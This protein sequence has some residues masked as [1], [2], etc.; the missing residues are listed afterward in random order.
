MSEVTM[1]FTA[2]EAQA[3]AAIQKL[4]GA[5]AKLN[6][7]ID[8]T[9]KNGQKASAELKRFADRVKEI[10]TTPIERYTAH[11]NKLQQAMS[12]GL[13]TQRD[14]DRELNRYKTSLQ[15]SSGAI[16][17]A[18]GSLAMMAAGYMSVSTAL[19]MYNQMLSANRQLALDAAEANKS[20]ATAQQEAMK[21]MPDLSSSE[22]TRLMSVV[23]P[24]MQ[25]KTGFP[26]AAAMTSALG[27]VYSAPGTEA[28][29]L[30]AVEAAALLNINTPANLGNQ[31]ASALDIA[32]QTGS[33]NMKENISFLLEAGA[34][35]RVSSPDAI[36][37]NLPRV[38]GSAVQASPKQDPK[39]AAMEAGALYGTMAGTMTDVQGDISRHAAQA[40]IMRLAEVFRE[41]KD[42]PGST[43]GRLQAIQ[44]SPK[45]K[46][47]LFS[48]S[49]GDLASQDAFRS[50]TTA[51]SQ[52]SKEFE[53]SISQLPFSED[54][55][56]QQVRDTQ[57]A[58]PQLRFA[59]A[60]AASKGA[61]QQLQLTPEMTMRAFIE[62]EG[63]ETLQA[64]HRGTAN[65]LQNFMSR[66][67]QSME[68][69]INPLLGGSAEETFVNRLK[70]QESG[71][72][73]YDR[74]P[75]RDKKLQVLKETRERFEQLK[76]STQFD[77]AAAKMEKAAD[78]LAKVANMF[79]TSPLGSM[80]G[81]VVDYT[82]RARAEF[83][84][85]Q[86]Q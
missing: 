68:K 52:Q 69:N 14:V 50:L 40:L 58:T 84:H 74:T 29:R 46:K 33:Q 85:A 32:R 7:S 80:A 34:V 2:D 18:V 51:G 27:E 42:D 53:A 65:G 49:F 55:Y 70:A 48:K 20:I 44:S 6:S 54:K 43:L 79:P 47:E 60:V 83:S 71:L 5:Q 82:G 16:S 1:V 28:Q 12:K 45:L 57:A 23:T 39:Q 67:E 9:A 73:A 11:T 64:T 63:E 76:Q 17:N 8:Q 59:T 35:N 72:R 22:R 3:W 36:A 15:S 13:L 77:S 86:S 10:N 25:A 78:A 38:V 37:K 21:N 62:G 19:A 41:K 24:A 66:F 31:A 61:R 26:D 81:R 4:A 75:D 56:N 30:G